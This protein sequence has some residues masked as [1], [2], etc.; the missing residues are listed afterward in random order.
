MSKEEVKYEI[1]KVL[2]RFSDQSLEDLLSFLKT[3]ESRNATL[4]SSDIL[5][6]ILSEDKELLQKLA[7]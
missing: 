2:D 1:N 4:F 7:Q 6:K 5:S 3:I